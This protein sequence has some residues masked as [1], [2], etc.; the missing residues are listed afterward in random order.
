MV[1]GQVVYAP[2]VML[3]PGQKSGLLVHVIMFHAQA[4]AVEA[5]GIRC[6]LGLNGPANVFVSMQVNGRRHLANELYQ[7]AF[8]L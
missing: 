3:I 7:E 5:H 8:S 2:V 4:A 1:G 6:D